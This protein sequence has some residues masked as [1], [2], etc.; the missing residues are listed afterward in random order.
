MEDEAGCA[1]VEIILILVGRKESAG[2]REKDI[3]QT[4]GFCPLKNMLWHP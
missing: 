3:G 2:K 1:A 4:I